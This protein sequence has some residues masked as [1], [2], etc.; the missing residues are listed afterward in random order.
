MPVFPVLVMLL[1]LTASYP[2]KMRMNCLLMWYHYSLDHFEF[3]LGTM[4]RYLFDSLL[5][6]FSQLTYPSLYYEPIV[7]RLRLEHFFGMLPCYLPTK[8]SNTKQMQ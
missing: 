6:S 4:S 2:K 7:F 1:N 5:N 3:D 8:K